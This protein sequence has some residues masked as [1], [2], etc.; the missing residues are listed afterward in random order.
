MFKKIKD[1][2]KAFKKAYNTI[3]VNKIDAEIAFDDYS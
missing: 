3:N 1:F 2:I